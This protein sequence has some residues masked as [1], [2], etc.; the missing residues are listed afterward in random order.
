M[1][2]AT[3]QKFWNF[4]LALSPRIHEFLFRKRT[5]VVFVFSGGTAFLADTSVLYLCRDFFNIALIPSVSAG[6]FVGFCV[7]FVLQ[8]FWA[9]GDLSVDKVRSQVISYFIVA[10][11]NYFVT[12]VLMYL[13]VEVI[14]FWYILAKVL[15]TVG[16]ACVTFF[17]Y[18]LF[19][20]NRS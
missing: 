20:F 14:G 16:V 4:I 8:K 1:F 11:G 18:R 7:S 10:L 5:A 9:F 15:V 3:E 13:L 17:I 12:V 6:F 19:I 2:K